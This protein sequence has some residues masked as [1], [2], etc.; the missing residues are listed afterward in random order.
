MKPLKVCLQ[1]FSSVNLIH[2]LE[3]N[4]ENLARMVQDLN[5]TRQKEPWMKWDFNGMRLAKIWVSQNGENL[6]WT[7]WDLNRIRQKVFWTKWDSDGAIFLK[8]W[9]LLMPAWLY[10]RLKTKK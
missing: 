2:F 8:F 6:A 1:P 4:G 10:G 3:L 7:V 5:R 9:V